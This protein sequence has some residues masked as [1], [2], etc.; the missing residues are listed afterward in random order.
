MGIGG[1][2]GR[3][4]GSS[5]RSLLWHM[6]ISFFLYE[7]PSV[8][9]TMYE[10]VVEA[11]DTITPG[12]YMEFGSFLNITTSPIQNGF[13]GLAVRSWL[14]LLSTLLAINVCLSL[15]T[16]ILG[17][18]WLGLHGIFDRRLRPISPEAGELVFTRGVVL[19]LRSPSIGSSPDSNNFFKSCFILLTALSV[20]PFDLG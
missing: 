16:A 13:L 18:R 12:V 20:N 4:T 19:R 6:Y 3:L 2:T 10:R 1:G 8:V 15:T 14:A 17:F 11:N 7:F 5:S 9:F